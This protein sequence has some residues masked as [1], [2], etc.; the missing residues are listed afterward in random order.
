MVI[1]TDVDSFS[2]ETVRLLNYVAVSRA[3]TLLFV[4]YD[5][6]KEMERQRMMVNSYSG[7]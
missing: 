3:S 5:T 6:H 1:L 7:L 2:D 4:L